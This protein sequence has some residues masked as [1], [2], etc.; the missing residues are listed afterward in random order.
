L[1]ALLVYALCTPA[2]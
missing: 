2:A 1:V